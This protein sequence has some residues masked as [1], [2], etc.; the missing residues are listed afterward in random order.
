[1]RINFMVKTLFL[2]IVLGMTSCVSSKKFKALE[3]ENNNLSQELADIKAQV[4]DLQQ[5][6]ATL[7]DENGEMNSNLQ[8][9]QQQLNQTESRLTQVEKDAAMKEQELNTMNKELDAAFAEITQAVNSTDAKVKEMANAL[10]LDLAD[11]VSFRTGSAAISPSD[12]EAIERIAQLLKDQPNLHLVIEGNADKRSINNDKYA[13][14]WELS[15]D[16]S[17]NVVRKLIDMGVNPEQLT[18]AG[19]AEFNPA[20]TDDP[21][22]K[23]TLAKNR[24]I[25]LMVVPKVGTL[26]KLANQ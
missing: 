14:N 20:V 8:N 19:R 5:Q 24:R 16:R 15:A 2:L 9:V 1:M 11:T 13:D 3:E 17:I 6:N 12:K 7:T 25:E 22:S 18:A 26:Y 4:S 21:D 10:Y 23:A